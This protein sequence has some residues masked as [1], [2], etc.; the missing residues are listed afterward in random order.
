[1]TKTGKAIVIYDTQFGNTE[2]IAR[3]LASGLREQGVQVDC[4]KASEVDINKLV[5]YDLL[6]VGGPTQAFGTS[7]PMKDF[8]GRLEGVE[9]RGKNAFAFDTKVRFIFTGSAAKGIEGRLRK[10]GMKIARSYASAIVKGN[11]GPL[12]EGEEEMF[13]QIGTELSR[14]IQST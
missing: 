1:M 12:E 13:K 5:G 3:A 8:L 6:A 14:S 10:L 7:K 11:E 4:I 2:K 9:L